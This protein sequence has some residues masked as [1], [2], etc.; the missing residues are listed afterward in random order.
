M[1]SVEANP[2]L[3]QHRSQAATGWG[4]GAHKPISR[5]GRIP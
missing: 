1:R 4:D 5:S 2:I 3:G